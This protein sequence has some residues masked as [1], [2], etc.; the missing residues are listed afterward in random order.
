MLLHHA[1][2]GVDLCLLERRFEPHTAHRGAVL[3]RRLDDVEARGAPRIGVVEHETLLAA[4]QAFVEREPQAL[5]RTSPFVTV[6]API[7][8]ST[9]LSAS[10]LFPA[11]G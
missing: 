3:P 9:Q 1:R 10:V 11:P 5:E 8:R 2:D 4:R 6:E 7:A